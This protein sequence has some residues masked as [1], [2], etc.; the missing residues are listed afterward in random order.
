MYENQEFVAEIKFNMKGEVSFTCRD[1]DE[2]SLF[3]VSKMFDQKLIE[4][5]DRGKEDII[6]N[7]VKAITKFASSN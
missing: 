5:E 6:N 1:G 4:A 2:R 3:M 7:M